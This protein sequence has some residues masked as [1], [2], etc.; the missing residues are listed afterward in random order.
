MI[1]AFRQV[2]QIDNTLVIVIAGDNGAS[3]EGGLS[4]TGNIMEQVNG[5]QLPPD[6]MPIRSFLLAMV[7][8]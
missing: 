8:C 1:D 3:L 4:G 5:V 6:A 2:G 7:T